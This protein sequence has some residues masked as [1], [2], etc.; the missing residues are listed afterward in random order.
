MKRQ[1]ISDGKMNWKYF[2]KVH[3][4][5]Y[6]A[7]GG[8]LGAGM[9]RIEVALVE[10]VGRKT[11]KKRIAPIACYPYKD[12]IVISAS[13]SGLETHPAWYHNLR[14]EPRCSVQLGREHFEAVA[15]ELSA[16]ERDA[17]L[18]AIFD[19]NEHYGPGTSQDVNSAPAPATGVS[20]STI[21]AVSWRY[22]RDWA[23]GAYAEIYI[24]VFEGREI[25]R[26]TFRPYN[27][28]KK[29]TC[30]ADGQVACPVF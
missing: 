26:I 15:E 3:S 8:R 21:G 17:I 18:P 2:G 14:A 28:D 7:S 23:W 13:N 10:T 5:L 24:P 29:I 30:P 16:Q 9:G 12:S 1:R 6:R 27:D 19:I 22:D 11:G 25:H 4:W 20:I